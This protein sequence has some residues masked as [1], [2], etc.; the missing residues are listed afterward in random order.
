M[1]AALEG[2]FQVARWLRVDAGATWKHWSS[3]E[4]PVENATLGAP[5]QAPPGYH[6]TVVPRVAGE[7]TLRRGRLELA[8]RLGYFFE[9]SPAP[10]GPMRAL[11]DADRHVVTAGGGLTWMGRTFS[12]QLDLFGQW[13]HLAESS[14]LGGDL[15]V[16]GATVGVDL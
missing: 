15:G 10:D 1:Q 13:H 4:N 9:W 14:R 2:A 7:A 6:D 5:P 12:F 8:A 3:Y 16:F 11:L